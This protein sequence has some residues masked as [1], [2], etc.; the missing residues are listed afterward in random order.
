MPS[1][2]L[3]VEDEPGLRLALTDR[4][5]AEG[6]EVVTAGDG[7]E[8]S[9]RAVEEHFDLLLLDVMLPGRSGFD[10]VRDLR[11]RGLPTP[12]ILLTARG[13]I[14]DRVVGLKLGADDYLVKP[15]DMAELLARIEARLRPRAAAAVQP[16]EAYRFGDVHVDFRSAEV[17]R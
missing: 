7:D 2:I 15:F 3:V 17:T 1:R 5:A 12:I 11:Q 14:V 9:R 10:L 4:L 8:G 13:E 6:Y 16:R